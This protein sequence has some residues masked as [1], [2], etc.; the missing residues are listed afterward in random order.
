MNFKPK[1]AAPELR[2]ALIGSLINFAVLFS[3]TGLVPAQATE[4]TIYTFK[5]GSDGAQPEGAL[6]AD[7]HGAL[8]GTTM[9]GGSLLHQGTLFKLTPPPSGEGPWTETVLYRFKGGSDGWSPESNLIF[10]KQGALYGTTHQGGPM[11]GGTVFKLTPS[12]GGQW[13]ESVLYSFSGGADGLLP[14]GGLIFDGQGALYGTTTLGGS[15]KFGTV[16]KLTPPSSGKGPW[17][18]TVLHN[19]AGSD[20]AEPG[21]GLIFDNQ[22]ALYGTTQIG[23]RSQNG[24]TVFKLTP[25]L[26]G[27]GPW[28]IT[29][30]H[31]FTGGTDGSQPDGGLI[32]DKQGAL[33]GTTRGGGSWG[34]GT[35]FKLTPPSSGKGPWTETVL[36]DFAG[37]SISQP[38]C[39]LL[40][41]SKGGLYGTTVVGSSA[42]T[43]GGSVFRLSPP[44]SGKTGKW[45]LTVLH[46]FNP[47]PSKGG[48]VPYAGLIIGRDGAFYGTL[49]GYGSTASG[50]GAVYRLQI[51]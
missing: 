24:S 21:A 42:G 10:D 38:L 49:R 9:L 23:G 43:T 45:T 26:S 28:T 12:D 4:A 5:G 16:F 15:L 32:F 6:I 50:Q 48:A 41:D 19:F 7:A 47:S 30:L 44:A 8:Y 27:K 14:A 2:R 29:V 20:G 11:Y 46:G 17:T 22:G 1:F 25:P 18:D 51:P 37:A 13:T 36:T 35:V 39:T 33:Y 3:T 34:A 40:L 31:S